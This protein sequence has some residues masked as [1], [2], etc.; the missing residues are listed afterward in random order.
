MGLGQSY[1]IDRKCVYNY[2]D[3]IISSHFLGKKMSN[4]HEFQLLRCEDLM[5]YFVIHDSKLKFTESDILLARQLI[6][7]GI[8]KE[9]NI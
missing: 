4:I 9:K 3:V 1:E 7:K 5:L 2:F 6:Q 8:D